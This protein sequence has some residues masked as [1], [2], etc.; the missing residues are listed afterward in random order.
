[1]KKMLIVLS[2]SFFL[3]GCDNAK[4]TNKEIDLSSLNPWNV[5]DVN[6]PACTEVMNGMLT[7]D[8]FSQIDVNRVKLN[9]YINGQMVEE[10]L[11]DIVDL[12]GAVQT[13]NIITLPPYKGDEIKHI[14]IVEFFQDA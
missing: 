11:A 7:K 4:N 8:V 9:H 3:I 2:L 12:D 1:M 14:L 10:N 13:R 6:I 5:E